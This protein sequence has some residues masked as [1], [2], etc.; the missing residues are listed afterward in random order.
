MSE[1]PSND[2]HELPELQVH[3]ALPKPRS[4]DP[5][6]A[7]RFRDYRFYAAGNLAS[8]IGQ[9]MLSVAL[10]LHIWRLT[11]SQM[12]LGFVGLVQALPILFLSL[13]A[14]HVAD[15]WNRKHIVLVTQLIV[16]VSLFSLSVL[17]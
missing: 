5:Y 3:A 15:I 1:S 13:S 7:L 8:I 14:G 2:S 12:A 17:T 4:H 6:A 10:G 11:N 16:A 9:Q